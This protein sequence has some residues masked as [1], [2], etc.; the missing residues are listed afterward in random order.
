MALRPRS[1]RS[2]RRTV[3]LG[4]GLI[5]GAFASAYASTEVGSVSAYAASLGTLSLVNDAGPVTS[6]STDTVVTF[7]GSA[8]CP[9]DS[10]RYKVTISGAGFP[11]G[12]NAVGT[13]NI[14]DVTQAVV[15]PLADGTFGVLAS[16]VG[17][18]VPLTGTATVD[19]ICIKG[20]STPNGD[21]SGQVTFIP[22][23]GSNSSFTT[24]AGPGGTPTPTPSGG[25]TPTPTPTPAGATPTPTPTPTANAT[26]TPTPTPDPSGTP[27]PTPDPS[28]T[29]CVTPEPTATPTAT[30]SPTP[31]GSQT[32]TVTVTPTPGSCASSPSP[33]PRPSTGSG[34]GEG[35]GGDGGN[36]ELPATGS[37][38]GPL[39]LLALML[40]AGGTLLIALSSVPI[41][42][43]EKQA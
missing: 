12:S 8:A 32:V 27:T 20:V 21:F 11:V 4:V 2:R 23:T 14:P 7:K 43:V 37:H 17:A 26:A 42:R 19:L 1:P 24:A 25:A 9:S 40:L 15:A 38:S 35:D 13:S 39:L 31:T 34:D 3:V 41:S 10:A 16:S 5:L 30:A 18:A 22:T 36:G 6:G 33:T 28:A 29:P